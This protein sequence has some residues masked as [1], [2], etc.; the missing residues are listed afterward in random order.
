MSN[1]P[2]NELGARGFF[3]AAESSHF[4]PT[5]FGSAL[6]WASRLENTFSRSMQGC[7]RLVLV[8]LALT[9]AASAQTNG[10]RGDYFSNVNLTGNPSYTRLDPVVNF[11][12]AG[13]APVVGLPTDNFS[14]RWSGKV[15]APVAGVY[16]FYTLTDDGARLWINGSQVINDW[17]GHPALKNT[18]QPIT[19]AAGQMCDI[20][21][22]YF[23]SAGD[24]VAKLSWSTASMPEVIIPQAQL[25]APSMGTGLQGEYFDNVNATGVVVATRIDPVINFNW[26]VNPPI[27]GVAN[28]NI[29]A[30]WTGQILADQTGTYTFYTNSD[31][32]ARLWVNGV[33]LVD[34]W[35]T[36]GTTEY[37]GTISLTAGQ[38]YD[39]ELDYF[40]GEGGAVIQLSWAGPSIAKAIIPQDHLFPP[41]S[42][43]VTPVPL[44]IP[45]YNFE[46]PSVGDTGSTSATSSWV[47][48]AAGISG[49]HGGF[50]NGNSSSHEGVQVAYIQG[51]GNFSQSISGFLPNVAYTL[52]F[53]AAQRNFSQTGQ[54]WK[55][56]L[57]QTEI[58]AYAP[59]QTAI[60]YTD[61][62]AEFE[63][64][65]GTFVLK[66][67]GTNTNGGDNSVLIDNIRIAPS[68]PTTAPT[69]PTG[70]VATPAVISTGIDLTWVDTASNE[71]GF[72]IERKTGAGGTYTQVGTAAAN[73][74]AYSDTGLQPSTLYYYKVR[75]TNVVGDSPYS[76][77]ASATT[78]DAK[79]S[80]TIIG[81]DG[82][83]PGFPDR[84]K[85]KAMDGVTST[86]FDAPPTV[87]DAW[88]GLDLG[89][90]ANKAITKVRYYPRNEYP[91]RM[92]GG[93]FQ[94]SNTADFS[95]G[96]VDLFVI[97]G[98]PTMDV[99]ASQTVSVSAGFRYVRYLSPVGGYGNV[100]EVEFYGHD[101]T[102]P[103]PPLAPT[104]LSAVGV[105][106]TQITLTWT[107][108]SDNESGFRIERKSGIDGTFAEIAV[109][110]TDTVSYGDAGLVPSATFYY[111][112][113][114]TNS[115]A[116]SNYSNIANGTTQDTPPGQSIVNLQPVPLNKV[117]FSD[118]FWQPRIETNRTV[119]LDKVLTDLTNDGS[120]ANF[121]KTANLQ[122]G[123]KQGFIWSDS[124]VYKMMEGM[125][126][127]IAYH[128]GGD[129]NL[130][131]KLNTIVNNVVAA[132]NQRSDGYLNTA[133]QLA[134]MGRNP[135]LA[136]NREWLDPYG[137]HE[138]YCMGHM[139]EAAVA[140]YK[141]SGSSTF[142]NVAR[143]NATYLAGQFGPSPKRS[144]IPGHQEV[145]LALFK[146]YKVPGF[147]LQSDLD[148]SKFYID[149][150]GRYS[151]GRTVYGEYC[152]DL[153]PIRNSPEP[154]GHG[155]R[156][157]YMWMAAV[158]VGN[159]IG[160]TA[161]LNASDKLWN[162]VVNKKM[163]V[164]G[165][166]GHNLYNE[167][168]APDYDLNNDAIWGETCSAVASM[169]WSQ[170]LGNV[171]GDSKYMD[172]ME[173]VMYNGYAAGRS[174]NGQ[175]LYYNNLM[176]RTS[177]TDQGKQGRTGI[178][179][180]A[181]NI[182]RTIPSIPGYQYATVA[183]DGIWT[184][185]YVAGQASIS[186]GGTT[187]G[188]QQTTSYPWEGAVTLAV[189]PATPTAFTLHLRIPDWALGAATA[190]LNGQAVDMSRISRGYLSIQKTWVAGDVVQL[191]LPMT[192]RRIY[193]NPNVVADQGRVAIARGP[194]IYCLEAADNPISV[195][196]IAIPDSAVLSVSS[197]TSSDMGEIRKITGTGI[198]ADNG[199]SVSFTM[200]PY[201]TWD[202]RSTSDTSDM[203]LMIPTSAANAVTKL[204]RGQTEN[205]V[206]SYSY[207]AQ[208]DSP[209]ALNDGILPHRANNAS[210]SQGSQD[211]S[212]PRLT[213]WNNL[214]TQEYV[215]Y[216][217]PAPIDAN[218][219]DVL[220][221]YDTNTGG[222]CDFP[223][224]F[225]VQ[226][227]DETMSGPEKWRN[228]VL[229]ANYGGNDL[230]SDYHFSVLR[231][232]PVRTTKLKLVIQSKPGKT[233][234]ILEWRVPRYTP[235]PSD[236]PS[237]FRGGALPVGTD[238]ILFAATVVPGLEYQVEESPDLLIWTVVPGTKATAE[239]GTSTME[240]QLPL[241]TDPKHFW[242]ASMVT[243]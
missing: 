146:L 85:D 132:Q 113:R 195:H 95:S 24:A 4:C 107:D 2:C 121:A 76:T 148:L 180:C 186:Y 66:F 224:S 234:G 237:G 43:A 1:T 169:M 101:F 117:Q 87:N 143:K 239:V 26:V 192:P 22:E 71:S 19:L 216:T 151:N 188:I 15:K 68:V 88:V 133:F 98:N 67:L 5:R 10:L 154:V 11:E 160:D 91:D 114:S 162:A 14:I 123:D 86:F 139:M 199:S 211:Q 140:H 104:G 135:S 112:V 78:G 193:M 225:Q 110:P 9:A 105:S 51:A 73:A 111:R 182:V 238:S 227:W 218:R 161:L 30:R 131:G 128:P 57:D 90:G 144:V 203:E 12:W 65:G 97:S 201:A 175:R 177:G 20:V 223:Q 155:V 191:T 153:Y 74:A 125:A 136:A 230:F 141:M 213:W 205:A 165:G 50:P 89:G 202:N 147:G 52:T 163:Y 209:A 46:T 129:S 210:A 187:V 64:D 29:S 77:P 172:V 37:S 48:A 179:C 243:K 31:D 119:S 53:S 183:S 138:S 137:A 178:A 62:T 35:I 93:K 124:D 207:K 56:I 185:M 122:G 134:N 36:Q 49:N 94:G 220:W 109:V 42:A 106:G 8:L 100:G 81:T 226:Y 206:V 176:R 157:P 168:Y 241:S 61:Y 167:G 118:T 127:A 233:A 82:F 194:M 55:V 41:P 235:L 38:K 116:N 40:Q 152:A 232:M 103:T 159:E 34:K 13:K 47:F 164:T 149:E 196:R 84:A 108:G 115:T 126:N 3:A 32:G 142:I 130:S 72:K 219:C 158:D 16:T 174:Y 99:F 212:I 83:Y 173:R 59:P 54:T 242:R 200:I 63:T 33:N 184:H 215:Q 228:V 79:L 181:T 45:N 171:R 60:N 21:F 39:I 208:N 204:D 96:V 214:G 222:A 145:E 27:S 197:S 7:L 170:R 18:S 229:D 23:D 189:A 75:A 120:V 6:A 150:R 221:F 240:W 69:A 102:P 156:A 231:F 25:F 58:G 17:N 198:N 190:A 217:F 236:P 92:N 166:T 44:V 80:G 28:T 70:L